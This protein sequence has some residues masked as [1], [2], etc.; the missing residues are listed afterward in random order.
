M[1]WVSLSMQSSN[2][3]ISQGCDLFK[4]LVVDIRDGVLRMLNN[5]NKYAVMH[6][7][8][9]SELGPI[10]ELSD[11]QRAAVAVSIAHAID[12]EI[13]RFLNH[14]DYYAPDLQIHYGTTLLNDEMGDCLSEGRSPCAEFSEF[15]EDG[16]FKWGA[17]FGRGRSKRSK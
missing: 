13:E 10:T 2:S 9:P 4:S 17:Q 14:L 5:P 11:G 3:P 12:S 8:P 1:F 7:L 16:A 15:D 6:G